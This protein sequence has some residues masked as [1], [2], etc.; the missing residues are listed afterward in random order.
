VR[1]GTLL[2][3]SEDMMIPNERYYQYYP[4]SV[5]AGTQASLQ[6]NGVKSIGASFLISKILQD[7]G[8]TRI[9]N[10][11]LD[12][13]RAESVLTIATY[14]AC[15]GNVIEYIEDWCDE[16]SFN[17]PISPQKSSVIFSSI[18]FKEQMTFFKSWLER[19]ETG[20]FLA[21]DVTS[22]S[23]RAKNIND[24]EWGYNRDGEKIPQINMGC[25]LS[26][27]TKLPMFY[28]TYPCS[29]ID[30]TN[31][32]YIMRYNKDL[33]IKNIVFVMNIGF[34]S[35]SNL[36]W[37]HVAGI[38]YVMAV[39]SFHKTTR[40]AIDEVRDGIESYRFR[41]G[42]DAYGRTIHA[43]CYGVSA[44][45]HVYYNPE[46]HS[47]SRSDLY[48]Q[49]DSQKD[50]LEQMTKITPKDAIKF[51]R[52]YD[53]KIGKNDEFKY[54]IN[55]DK[56][57]YEEKNCGFFCIFSNTE[58]KVDEIYSVYRNKDIIEKGFDDLKNHID[59][60]R[61]KTHNDGTTDGKLFCAFIALISV[62]VIAE[63]LRIMNEKG[64]KRRLSKESLMNQLN[65]I[66][67]VSLGDGLDIMNAVTKR[68]REILESFGFTESD[69][70]SY[71][72]KS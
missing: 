6:L 31:M 28:V 67:V 62:S 51:S 58:Y 20:G 63:K 5:V 36:K 23:T 55:Y 65:K 13:I 39:D 47:L 52:F 46:L 57:D 50:A 44:N 34:C 26:F 60:K 16:Y 35:T 11:T 10:E 4:Q 7:L 40:S 68:Q 61:L 56:V 33:G 29:I 45:M 69:L 1:I 17:P 37:L 66:K 27:K 19:N 8:V 70:R 38:P 42:D 2:P 12:P 43:R 72:L 3:D 25:Y 71:A 30:K 49:I 32:S 15:H 21:Y 41:C 18:S 22:F 53:I 64:G 14:M 9:L 59:M 48:R 24:A 54:T